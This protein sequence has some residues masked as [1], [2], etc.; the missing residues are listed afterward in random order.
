MVARKLTNGESIWWEQ[1]TDTVKTIPYINFVSALEADAYPQAR[2]YVMK[3]NDKGKIVDACAIGQMALNLGVSMDALQDFLESE[4]GWEGNDLR[5]AIIDWN[6]KQKK[7]IKQIARKLKSFWKEQNVLTNTV[8][9][10]G[11][12]YAEFDN[13]QGVITK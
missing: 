5:G 10:T 12:N 3:D 13:W 1:T 8:E 9:L 6:D 7:S 4:I 2:G 11:Y